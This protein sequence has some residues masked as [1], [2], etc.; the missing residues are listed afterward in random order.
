MQQSA[1]RA[2]VRHHPRCRE[3][4]VYAAL[5]FDIQNI[6]PCSCDTNQMR[7]LCLEG[8]DNSGKNDEYQMSVPSTAI[9]V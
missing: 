6:F 8:Y 2:S 5:V 1:R 9:I 7:A 4:R 3:S